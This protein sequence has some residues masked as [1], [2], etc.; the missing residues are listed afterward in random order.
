MEPVLIN[1]IVEIANATRREAC[2]WVFRRGAAR[3]AQAARATAVLADRD[4]CTPDDITQN[5]LPVG[6]HRVIA[7]AYT[8]ARVR[9]DDHGTYPPGS[10][11]AILLDVLEGIDSPA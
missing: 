2:R 5:L 10:A 6:A 1:Y 11:Q 8:A 7:K 4:Y 3:A 9:H